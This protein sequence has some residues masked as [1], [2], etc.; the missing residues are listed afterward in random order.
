MNTNGCRYIK[1]NN[2]NGEQVVM[3][4]DDVNYD[5]TLATIQKEL[6]N[7]DHSSENLEAIVL[8]IIDGLPCG[9]VYID[10]TIYVDEHMDTYTHLGE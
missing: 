3:E 6:S 5:M 1:I 4:V 9:I 10:S 8:N 7:Y 2:F